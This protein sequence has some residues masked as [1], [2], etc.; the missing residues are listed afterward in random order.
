MIGNRGL[1][2]KRFVIIHKQTGGERASLAPNGDLNEAVEH[3]AHASDATHVVLHSF[4]LAGLLAETL[5]GL[6]PQLAHLSVDALEII[7]SLVV[8]LG[9]DEL[10]AILGD[11]EPSE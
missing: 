11:G 10:V 6:F 5:Q 3:G 8:I 1:Q 4:T 9:V 7:L 2:K